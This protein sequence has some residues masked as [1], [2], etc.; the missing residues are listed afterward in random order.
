MRCG[1]GELIDLAQAGGWSRESLFFFHST[2][3]VGGFLLG[4]HF[5]R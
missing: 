1:D 4:F 2:S 3:Q 5:L